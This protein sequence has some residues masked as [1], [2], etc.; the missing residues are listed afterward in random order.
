MPQSNRDSYRGHHPPTCTCVACEKARRRPPPSAPNRSPQQPV[1]DYDRRQLSRS[2]RSVSQ[3]SRPAQSDK[4]YW[5]RRGTYR[6]LLRRRRVRRRIVIGCIALAAIACALILWPVESYGEG[7]LWDAKAGADDFVSDVRQR[8]NSQTNPIEG[9]FDRGSDS[10]SL[11]P[12]SGPNALGIAERQ[13]TYA[14]LFAEIDGYWHFDER[15]PAPGTVSVGFR[16]PDECKETLAKAIA[17]DEV[18]ANALL[19]AVVKDDA[20]EE[21]YDVWGKRIILLK[22]LDRDMKQ[23]CK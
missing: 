23:G 7:A 21:I 11:A 8:F 14:S 19:V 5:S 13:A 4:D 3:S 16:V 2:R 18:L 12:D 15:Q 1:R 6:S 17:R 10:V 9:V 22:E 20:W